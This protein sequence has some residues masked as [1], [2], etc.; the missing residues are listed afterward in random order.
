V[1]GLYDMTSLGLHWFAGVTV[2]RVKRLIGIYRSPA[3]SA[4]AMLAVTVSLAA[5]SM[6]LR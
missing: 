5:L 3:P 4:M 6:H 2:G 1:I